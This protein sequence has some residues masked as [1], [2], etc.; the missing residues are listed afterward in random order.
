M[1]C[2]N[3][4]GSAVQLLARK[5]LQVQYY[6]TTG[7][8]IQLVDPLLARLVRGLKVQGHF[9]FGLTSNAHGTQHSNRVVAALAKYEIRFSKPLIR[10]EMPSTGTY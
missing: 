3:I 10:G 1:H 4:T 5:D 8:D 2:G 7:S 6:N 9:V